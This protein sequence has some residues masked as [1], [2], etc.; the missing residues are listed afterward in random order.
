MGLSSWKY[1][2]HFGQSCDQ[3]TLTSC[4]FEVKRKR[5]RHRPATRG[6]PLSFTKSSIPFF[7]QAF[8]GT[9]IFNFPLQ[10][11]LNC[12][13]AHCHQG[14]FSFAFRQASVVFVPA[15]CARVTETASLPCQYAINGRA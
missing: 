6:P 3:T 8:S 7:V 5:Y 11:P 10:H 13:M 1:W 2:Y 14:F 12:T 15:A 4:V 9:A